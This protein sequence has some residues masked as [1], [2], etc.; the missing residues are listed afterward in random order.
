[1]TTCAR[2]L[3]SGVMYKYVE[4]NNL[5]QGYTNPE[6]SEHPEGLPKK[7]TDFYPNETHS[8]G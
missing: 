6:E 8:F 5:F 1:M 7:Q 4:N 3:T 2:E